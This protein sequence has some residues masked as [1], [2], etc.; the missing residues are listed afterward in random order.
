M[1]PPLMVATPVGDPGGTS[2]AAAGA[3]GHKAPA[4]VVF[5]AT[6]EATNGLGRVRHAAL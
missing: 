4:E 1:G 2:T 6:H 3:T 5:G